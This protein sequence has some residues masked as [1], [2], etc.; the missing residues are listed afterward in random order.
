M[1]YPVSRFFSQCKAFMAHTRSRQ[2]HEP[3]GFAFVPRSCGSYT[4]EKGVHPSLKNFIRS[5]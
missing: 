2:A 4:T 5:K 1:M 3:G